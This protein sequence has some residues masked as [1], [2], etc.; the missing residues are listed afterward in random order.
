MLQGGGG[1]IRAGGQNP[2]RYLYAPDFPERH[3]RSRWLQ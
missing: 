3:G 2:E 1:L